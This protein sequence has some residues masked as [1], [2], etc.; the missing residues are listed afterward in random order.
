MKPQRFKNKRTGRKPKGE[1]YPYLPTKRQAPKE[2]KMVVEK[3]RLAALKPLPSLH[4]RP[5]KW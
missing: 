3:E 2:P 5:L 4:L 1:R